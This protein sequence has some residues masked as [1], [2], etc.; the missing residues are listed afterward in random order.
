MSLELRG[1]SVWDGSSMWMLLPQILMSLV[2][3]KKKKVMISFV[4]LLFFKIKVESS[5]LCEKTATVLIFLVVRCAVQ[6]LER[7]VYSFHTPSLDLRHPEGL[8]TGVW[9]SREVLI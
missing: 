1:Q 9:S 7:K 5:P 2:G 4:C 3:W 6:S 8:T